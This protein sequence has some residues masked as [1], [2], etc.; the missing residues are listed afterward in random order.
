MSDQARPKLTSTHWRVLERVAAGESN[1][2]IAA[3]LGIALGT[4]ASH[5]TTIYQRLP[6]A[7]TGGRRAAAV[8]WYLTVGRALHDAERSA[9][10]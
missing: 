1:A 4:V 6:H 5:M 10:P 9:A 2:T 8:S 7:N 3:E